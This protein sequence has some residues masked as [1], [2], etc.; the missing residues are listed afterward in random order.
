MGKDIKTKYITLGY[1][2][3]KSFHQLF[4]LFRGGGGLQTLK[5]VV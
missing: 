1:N 3:S 4:Q 5:S 2:I